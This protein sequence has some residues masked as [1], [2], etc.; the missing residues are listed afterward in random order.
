M[1]EGHWEMN[2]TMKTPMHHFLS[3]D[4]FDSLHWKV[5][6]FP[7]SGSVHDYLEAIQ[8]MLYI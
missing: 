6:N 8:M 3:L 4:Q 5:D 7:Q 1:V 2:V